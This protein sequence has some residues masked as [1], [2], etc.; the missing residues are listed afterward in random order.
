MHISYDDIK[1]RECCLLLRPASLN[2]SFTS[3]EI[4]VIRA[5]LADLRAAPK[6]TD[7]PVNYRRNLEQGTIEIEDIPIRIIC[8]IISSYPNPKDS[9]IERIKILSILNVG[10]QSGLKQNLN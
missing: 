1:L 3:L 8:Q 5:C 9:Q 7:S 6:L 2:S 10:L 4:K